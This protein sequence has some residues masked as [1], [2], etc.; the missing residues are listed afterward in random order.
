MNRNIKN[1]FSW[2]GLIGILLCCLLCGCQA[3]E[4]LSSESSVDGGMSAVSSASEPAEDDLPEEED[5]SYLDAVYDQAQGE[6]KFSIYFIR[7]IKEYVT[8]S[9]VTHAGD[10]TLLVSPDGK[11]MLIDLNNTANG[12]EIV[13]AM[14]HLGIDTLD[15]LV[16]SHPHAD[17]IGSYQMLFRYITVKE[18]IMNGHDYSEDSSVFAGLMRT[19]EEKEIPITILAEGDTF[20]FGAD[21]TVECYNPPTDFVFASDASSGNNGSL[22]LKFL[23]GDSTYL[24]GGDLYAEQE[25]ALLEKYG[26]QLQSDVVKINHHGY[27]TS[28]TRE[29]VDTISA[30]IAV[31]ESNGIQSNV[32]EGRYRLSGAT[33]LCTG[34]D[35]A[36][37]VHTTGD[38]T[39]EVQVQQE[40]SVD[41]YGLLETENGYFTVG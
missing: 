22:L 3:G 20:S 39:Y 21:V 27:D 9:S 37:A 14:Q 16:F 41:T 31:S 38:G 26:N 18:V 35:G 25:A 17:H 36:I 33:T 2:Y 19:I 32:V 10:S 40:R 29:W 24:T 23:Y 34:L 28:N 5:A 13:A 12:G 8:D 4:T 7:A 1:S 6:G 11:T 30:K 15:Y